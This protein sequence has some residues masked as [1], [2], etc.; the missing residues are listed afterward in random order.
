MVVT[1]D[2]KLF[3]TGADR[4]NG[5]LMFFLLLA[6]EIKRNIFVLIKLKIFSLSGEVPCEVYSNSCS[7]LAI[8]LAPHNSLKISSNL[9]TQCFY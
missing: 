9:K 1:I 3:R 2:I 5:I 7:F 4:H 8:F 6:A